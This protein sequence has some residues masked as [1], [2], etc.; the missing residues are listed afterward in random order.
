MPSD[1]DGDNVYDIT[2]HANDGSHD[3]TQDVAI[4]VNDV[5]PAVAASLGPVTEGT[6]FVGNVNGSGGDTGSVTYSLSPAL[7][8]SKFT[9]DQNGNL[10]FAEAPDFENPMDSN[11]DGSTNS[12]RVAVFVTDESGNTAPKTYTINVTNAAPGTPGDIDAASN[13]I[14]E[15][16]AF[17]STVGI[18]GF[19][20]D[21]AGSLTY[22]LTDDANGAF[23]IDA[24]TG[25]VTVNSGSLIDTKRPPDT[26]TRLLSRRRTARRQRQR[27]LPLMLTTWQPSQPVDND[28]ASGGSVAEN[29]VN[30]STVGITALS[31]DLNGGTLTYALTNDAG[32]RFAINSSTGVVTV[33]NSSLLDRE[34]ASSHDVVVT[35]S[36][37]QGTSASQTFTIALTDVNDN[38]PVFTSDTTASVNEGT[39]ASTVVYDANTTDAD[40]T[41]A[42]NT[43]TYSLSGD[44]AAKFNID[45]GTGEVRFNASPDFEAPVDD[46]GDNVYDITVHANDG[47]NDTA[48]AV[49]VTVNNVAPTAIADSNAAVNE[50][51]EGATGATVGITALSTD[52]A[53]PTTYSLTNN[54]N[55]AFQI[56][57]STGVVT[58]LDGSKLDYETATSAQIEVSATNGDNVVA[59]SYTI[60]VKDVNDNAPMFTSGATASLIENRATTTV[61]YD[62]NVTDAD[63]TV[64]NMTFS[65]S[66]ADASLFT[67]GAATGEVRFISSP[68][69]EAPADADGD[70]IYQVTVIANDGVNQTSQAVAISV[71]DTAG[72]T[73]TGTSGSDTINGTSGPT[74]PQGGSGL[75]TSEADTISGGAGN[76]TI[77]GLG[78]N[79]IIDGG[80]GNDI[81]SG[82]DEYADR[83]RRKGHRQRRQWQHHQDIGHW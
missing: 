41:S 35:A 37:G 55:G 50:V 7:D 82:S 69:F 36:D 66:G 25:V 12:Y 29:A 57:I 68:D 77:D 30:G 67:I 81:L 58:V 73:I 22:S 48:T 70:N 61:V 13:H 20:T 52:G 42:N 62:A 17:G 40:V 71:T 44:D 63:A 19:A 46:D 38:A 60:A 14:A 39:T 43:V 16:A 11:S 75:A 2:V 8:G 32:G 47:V 59:T 53:G 1:D 3:T 76:D 27:R 49:A 5:A 18:T 26:N 21:G 4:A 51:N 9:I 74:Q 34:S 72:S 24:S 65:L 80:A 28:A 31:S 23:D 79:D 15:G 33:A 10:S 64:G 6:L 78:G 56:D 83:R 45:S 54:A